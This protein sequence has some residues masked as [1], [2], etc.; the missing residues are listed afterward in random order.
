MQATEQ[1]ALLEWEYYFISC[2]VSCYDGKYSYVLRKNTRGKVGLYHGFY[3]QDGQMYSDQMNSCL[4]KKYAM[5]AFLWGHSLN[6]V[7]ILC[8]KVQE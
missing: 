2:L 8:K 6:K 1:A 7:Q 3:P 5:V 4:N